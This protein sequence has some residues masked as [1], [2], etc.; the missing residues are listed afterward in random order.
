[1]HQNVFVF[2]DIALA[3]RGDKFSFNPDTLQ[4]LHRNRL[5]IRR[6]SLLA[7][8]NRLEFARNGNEATFV[9]N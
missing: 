8:P 4:R 5:E 6:L 1:M 9:D 7:T 3:T 2:C